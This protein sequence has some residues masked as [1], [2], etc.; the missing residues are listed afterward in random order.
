MTFSRVRAALIVLLA[1][2]GVGGWYVLRQPADAQA[3]ASPGPG[4]APPVPVEIAVVK[5]EPVD[6]IDRGIGTVQAYSSVTVRSRVDGQI[7]KVGFSEGQRVKAGDLLFQIDPRP[8]ETQLASAEADLA[9]DQAQLANAQ[10]NLLRQS[11]LLKNQFASRQAYDAQVALVAQYRAAIQA[12][13]AAIRG[14]QLN[15]EYARITSPID[16]LTGRRQVDLGNLVR[17][18]EATPLVVV[19]QIQPIYVSFT[20]P[21]QDLPAARAA[22]ATGQ[23]PAVHA[24]AQDDVRRLASGTLTLID[25][26]ID[27]ATGTVIL[28]GEFANLEQTL[29]PGQLVTARLVLEHRAAGITIPIAAVQT[30]PNG[31][32]AYVA[33]ADRTVEVRPITVAQMEDGVA[34]V[35]R[36]VMPGEQ[37]VTLGQFRLKPGARV[38]IQQA[39]ASAAADGQAA[40]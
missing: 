31:R 7:L 21:Q 1:T 40:R 11:A 16:G 24:Y 39:T 25:N 28:K 19:A 5:H 34:V 3:P 8:F 13:Q 14:V 15:L 9:R 12:D 30:G 10:A 2:V 37:V 32:F 29:W 35:D 6:I 23:A 20:L 27:P 4:E 36:G 17:A 18:N 26:Q 33:K 22:L 38:S